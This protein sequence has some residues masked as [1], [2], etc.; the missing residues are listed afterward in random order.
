MPIYAFKCSEC[1]TE[2]DRMLKL[3]DWDEPQA[4]PECEA[5]PCPRQITKVNFNLPGDGWV[6]KNGR[7]RKQMAA[8]NVRLNRIGDERRRDAPPVT[9]V[10]NVEGQETGTWKEA[11]KLAASKGKNAAS[12][13]TKVRREKAGYK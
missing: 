7:I 3:A 12:Y 4:C 2:F 8:K 5:S 10:P 1:E 9:L 6:S 13:E 11:Q